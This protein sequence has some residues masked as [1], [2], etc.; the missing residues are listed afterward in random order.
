MNTIQDDPDFSTAN[1]GDSIFDIT[2][3]DDD[4]ASA[5]GNISISSGTAVSGNPGGAFSSGNLNW[6]NTTFTIGQGIAARAPVSVT[7]PDIKE[8]VEYIIVRDDGT[9]LVLDEQDTITPR[10]MIGIAKFLQIV[11][12]VQP[13][14]SIA[15]SSLIE[16][17]NIERHFMPAGDSDELLLDSSVFYVFLND[18]K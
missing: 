15:W 12:S 2:L 1:T 6:P 16:I 4:D 13:G 17:L 8:D 18:P 9:T 7:V 5:T 11:Q 3:D 10:E 14:V